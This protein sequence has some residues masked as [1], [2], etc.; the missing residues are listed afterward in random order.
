MTQLTNLLAHL[1]NDPQVD[2][3]LVALAESHSSQLLAGFR[4]TFDAAAQAHA[5]STSAR[6]STRRMTSKRPSSPS[7]PAPTVLPTKL[8][9][10]RISGKKRRPKVLGDFFTRQVLSSLA[11]ATTGAQHSQDVVIPTDDDETL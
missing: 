2:P 6:G 7:S 4:Q 5:Q 8:A 10:V 1:R 3:A 9:K 11:H